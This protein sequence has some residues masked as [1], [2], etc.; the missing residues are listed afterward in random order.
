MLSLKVVLTVS[1]VL[2]SAQCEP[3]TQTSSSSNVLVD[4]GYDSH[5]T[6]YSLL[7]LTHARLRFLDIIEHAQE[8]EKAWLRILKYVEL[9]DN[10]YEHFDILR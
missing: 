2:T 10:C 3:E 7:D 5:I 6:H 1:V 8:I 4:E 9:Y